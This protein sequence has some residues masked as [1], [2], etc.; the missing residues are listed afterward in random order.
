M[1]LHQEGLIA[2]ALR[3]LGKVL[4]DLLGRLQIAPDVIDPV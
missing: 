2:Q 4:T 1:G 3:Q